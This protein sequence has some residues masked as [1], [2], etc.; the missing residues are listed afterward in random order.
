MFSFD[1]V[2]FYHDKTIERFGGSKGLRD[3]G[4]LDSALKRP[5]QTFASEELYPTCFEKAAAI[6]ESVTLNHPFIDGNKRTA[7][8]LCEA[9]LE[10]A[11]YTIMANTP[12]VYNFLIDISTGSLPFEEIVIWLRHN[13][14]WKKN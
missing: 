6:V 2:I 3:F 14:E 7:F 11:G 5:W 8:I 13:T 9:I 4:A 12:T 10:D 1:E